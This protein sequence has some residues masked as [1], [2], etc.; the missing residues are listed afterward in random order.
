MVVVDEDHPTDR[1]APGVSPSPLAAGDLLI[2]ISTRAAGTR[3]HVSNLLEGG[4]FS[5]A[6]TTYESVPH[7]KGALAALR[8]AA[9]AHPADSLLRSLTSVAVAANSCGQPFVPL[10]E[11]L[12]RM[13]H[14]PEPTAPPLE[15]DETALIAVA[16]MHLCCDGSALVHEADQVALFDAV[17]SSLRGD[18]AHLVRAPVGCAYPAMLNAHLAAL[19]VEHATAAYRLCDTHHLPSSNAA[20]DG[21]LWL[22]RVGSAG[23]AVAT[24]LLARRRNADDLSPLLQALCSSADGPPAALDMLRLLRHECTKRRRGAL[25]RAVLSVPH[26]WELTARV[27]R[28]AAAAKEASQASKRACLMA[29]V[30]ACRNALLEATSLTWRPDADELLDDRL[31]DRMLQ[32]SPTCAAS[33]HFAASVLAEQVY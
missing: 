16:L 13:F 15:G 25:L 9:T 28:S 14:A 4:E 2:R 8:E 23:L 18:M 32:M 12:S 27:E 17:N 19:V 20:A 5:A 21:I 11:L 22:L 3:V 6:L 33:L 30:D 7:A 10:T 1:A 26:L 24:D 29:A 31:A